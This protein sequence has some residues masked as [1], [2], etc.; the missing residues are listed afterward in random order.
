MD[1]V[2]EV[3][4]ISIK[5]E[6]PH[7]PS[8]L[9]MNYLDSILKFID[10]DWNISIGKPHG[11]QAY[12]VSFHKHFGTEPSYFNSVLQNDIYE[13]VDYSSDVLGNA[14]GVSIGLSYNNKKT[15]CNISDANLQTGSTMEALDFIGLNQMDILL[16]ID[17]NDLQ[18]TRNM[19]RNINNYKKIFE[20]F[21]WEVKIIDTKNKIPNLEHFINKSNPRIILFSTIKG[22][23]VKEM[24]LDP[25]KWHYK[26][27]KEENEI[28]YCK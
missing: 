18:L 26:I 13:F 28:T 22:Y 10:K 2:K 27:L 8:A 7:I 15:W 12:F 14:L 6:L 5:H 16:S 11:A 25:S 24:E 3:I 21:G 17:F 20:A 4:D 9:S 19:P 23:G 1:F